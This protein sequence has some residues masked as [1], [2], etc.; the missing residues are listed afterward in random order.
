MRISER[1]ASLAFF[2]LIAL[3]PLLTFMIMG[4]QFVTSKDFAENQIMSFIGDA[5]GDIAPTPVQTLFYSNAA[6]FGSYAVTSIV[7]SLVIL[8]S[9]TTVFLYLRKSLA[10][11]FSFEDIEGSLVQRTVKTRLLA[12]LYMIILFLLL[13][14]VMVSH[15]Y[16][17]SLFTLTTQASF[18]HALSPELTAGLGV[19]LSFLF[20]LSFFS[21]VYRMVS[22]RI[23]NNDA[24]FGGLVAACCF[25]GINIL[26]SAVLVSK[27]VLS[28]YGVLG[29]FI[30]L[31]LYLYYLYMAFFVGALAAM[32]HTI[33]V[34]PGRNT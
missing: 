4:M 12:I 26:F 31:G 34:F 6:A 10:A 23:R 13:L 25:T 24:L 14:L 27:T 30:A 29:V 20:A 2:T 33:I 11:I 5:L 7:S 18:G 17:S 28:L 9:M 32:H 15:S 1:A 22:D 19:F 8:W 21:A 16:V 3:V